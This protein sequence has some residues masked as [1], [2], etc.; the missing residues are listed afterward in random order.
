MSNSVYPALDGSTIDV[1]RQAMYQTTVQ[2][3]SG[4]RELRVNNQVAAR[5][6]YRIT[7]DFLRQDAATNEA[8]TLLAFF[9]THRGSW[10][11]FFYTDPYS[12]TV[13]TQSFGTGDATSTVFYLTDELGERIAGTTGTPLIYKAG[14]LQTVTTHYTYDANLAKVTFVAAPAAAAALTWSGTFY[15]R[16]RFAEDG[17]SLT[18][19]VSRVWKGE[20]N[21]VSVLP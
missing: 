8:Q 16:C 11:S 5:Y 10:D 12:N 13:T 4:G 7:Y 1:Q 9:S 2:T 15:R 21:L 18:R 20:V 17:L 14:V 6:R 19:R 3:E